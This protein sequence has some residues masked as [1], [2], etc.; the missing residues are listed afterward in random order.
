[1]T[2]FAFKFLLIY[3]F[4]LKNKIF[5]KVKYATISGWFQVIFIFFIFCKMSSVTARCVQNQEEN[6]YCFQV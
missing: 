2:P 4:I 3:L 1:M 6:D 5:Q